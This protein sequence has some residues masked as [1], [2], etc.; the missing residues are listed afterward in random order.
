MKKFIV[1][2]TDKYDDLSTVWVMADNAEDA[3]R[4]VRREYWDVDTIVCVYEER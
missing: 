1:K 2:Y 3:K 4:E